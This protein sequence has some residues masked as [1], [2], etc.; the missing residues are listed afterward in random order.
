[1]LLISKGMVAKMDP[2]IWTTEQRRADALV[3]W[4]T[5][6]RTMTQKQ[7]EDLEE[8][9]V[10]FGLAD[11]IIIN[12]DDVI[13]GGHMRDRILLLMDDYGPDSLIDVRVPDRTL[14]EDE[15]SELNIR[16]NKISGEWDM[17]KLADKFEVKDLLE[18]GFAGWEIGIPDGVDVDAEWQGMPEFEQEDADAFRTIHIHFLNQNA[19]NEFAS[20]IGQPFTE[21][22][23]S[24]WHPKM[25]RENLRQ[26]Q[27]ID[28]S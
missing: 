1:M 27:I 2:I 10:R 17:D 13:I 25:E 5:N 24:V 4:D 21:K 28:E 7:S 18:W 8:S 22:T 14:T 19:V 15:V 11:P 26:F 16:L 20:L 12:T 6:P 23:K 3:P 9:L